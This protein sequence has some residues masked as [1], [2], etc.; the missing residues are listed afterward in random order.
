[1]IF[2][3]P[4][5]LEE[6]KLQM[7]TNRDI[8]K[9]N[10]GERRRDPDFRYDPPDF[11][12]DVIPSGL[13]KDI[14]VD[15]QPVPFLK[16]TPR[17]D[18]EEIYEKLVSGVGAD[19][20]IVTNEK[21][22]KQSKVLYRVDLFPPLALLDVSKVLEEGA[23]KYA[24]DNW[25]NIDCNDHLNHALIHIFAYL[26]KDKQDDHLSHAA[27]RIMMALEMKLVEDEK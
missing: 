23:R 11:S 24:P 12:A 8:L 14:I 21:G 22:G 13:G 25:R 5:R 16:E 3:F 2:D 6:G 7:L 19:A 4:K 10:R 18:R 9:M 20:P 1:M 26:A 17:T 15:K 27:C